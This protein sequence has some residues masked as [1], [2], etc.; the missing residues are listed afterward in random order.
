MLIDFDLRIN[1]VKLGFQPFLAGRPGRFRQNRV[2]LFP[3]DYKDSPDDRPAY[4]SNPQEASYKKKLVSIDGRDCLLPS[5]GTPCVNSWTG[6]FSASY[7][8]FFL[9]VQDGESS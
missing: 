8:D 5:V 4:C 2:C 6:F 9:Q 7:F 1:Y 3:A